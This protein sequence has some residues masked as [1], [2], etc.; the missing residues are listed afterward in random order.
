MIIIDR[1]MAI[2]GGDNFLLTVCSPNLISVV[3][4]SPELCVVQVETDLYYLLKKVC[5][6]PVYYLYVTCMLPV[7]QVCTL[8]LLP[9]HYLY[10]YV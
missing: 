1:E 2:S 5:F 10:L 8:R 6:L 7:Y 4:K 9:A 3:L